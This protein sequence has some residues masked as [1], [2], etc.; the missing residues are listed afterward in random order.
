MLIQNQYLLGSTQATRAQRQQTEWPLALHP[1]PKKVAFLGVATGITPGAALLDT[2]VE[3]IVAVEIS[4]Q[5]VA[6]AAKWFAEANLGLLTSPRAEVLV[7]DARTWLTAQKEA[8]FE[9]I[10]SDLFLPWGPGDGRLYTLEHFSSAQSAL[11]NEGLFVLWLPL[12][13]LTND[14]VMVILNT[15]LEVFGEADL[16]LRDFDSGQPVLGCFG[17]KDPAPNTSALDQQVGLNY[18]GR[19]SRTT[20]SAPLNTLGNLWIEWNAGFLRLLRPQ[21]TP[22]LVGNKGYKWADDLRHTLREKAE[23]APVGAKEAPH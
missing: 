8:S 4:P 14:Q 9:V 6:A 19:I 16:I 13:Q 18:L 11:K 3:S 2:R 22:Y 10:I 23:K 5:V 12:Y 21:S 7:E 1:N 15:F 17:W 20:I